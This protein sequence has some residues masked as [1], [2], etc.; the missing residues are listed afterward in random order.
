MSEKGSILV[1][2]D[3]Q[4]EREALARLLR[5]E[6]YQVIMA[7]DP[8]EAL[9]HV[10]GQVGLVISDLRMGNVSGIDLLRSWR[11]RRPETPFILATA[12]GDVDS[13]VTAMK[14]G[15]EDYLTKPVDP[16]ALLVLVRN[17]MGR[18]DRAPAGPAD[19]GLLFDIGGR[20][21]LGESPAM[22]E[23]FE[24]VRRAAPTDGLVLILGES[25]TGKEL[26]ASA[27]H[28][29]S[30]RK[31][32]PYIAVNV[33]ALPESLVEAE[34]FGYVPGAFTGAE[35]DRIGRFEA[36]DRGTLFID[37]IG[38]FPLAAQAKLLRVL[39]NLT[40]NPIGS[41][42]ERRVDVRLVAA[43]SRNLPELVAEGAFRE[44]LFYRLN[45]LTID[46]PPLRERHEDLPL[47]IDAFLA[48]A[49]EKNQRISPTMSA[50]LRQFMLAYDWPGNVRQ[51]RNAIENM[52]VMASGETLSLNDLPAYL[53]GN[54]SLLADTAASASTDR[55]H[56]V[57]RTAILSVLERCGGNR[58]H[59][60]ATL[61]ISVRTLQRKLKTWG[62]NGCQSEM[63][64]D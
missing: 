30:R 44:D 25:G 63:N 41:N 17:K 40:V 28:A 2:E 11:E 1:V 7:R 16:D 29:Y 33:A 57:E 21:I 50:E 12:Y 26:V 36:A 34:L 22:L 31:E 62:S 39:D 14:L 10:D 43:T 42:E 4:G 24:R 13:A 37:E 9:S 27:I 46:L 64:R 6:E 23:V 15:A 53:S 38:D 58:T 8:D 45:V 51:L 56:D 18:C 55:L 47:L 60:A 54:A 59:A 3:E 49:C 32:G 61:G 35:R 20:P 5:M 52:V 19:K 48:D